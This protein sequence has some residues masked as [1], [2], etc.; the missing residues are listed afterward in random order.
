MIKTDKKKEAIVTGIVEVDDK[1]GGGIPLGSLC[2][3]EGHSDAGKSVLCQH[4]TNGTLLNAEISVAYYTTENNIR[5]LVS[6]M[7]SLNMNILDHFLADRLRIFPLTFRSGLPHGQKPFLVLTHHF[8][9]L[10]QEFKLI[11]VDSITLLVA[12]SEPVAIIDFFSR[13]KA[14]CDQGKTII[15]VAHSYAFEE[16]ILSRT[17]SLCDARFKLRLEQVGE[18]MIKL[19]EVLKVRGADRPTGD[20]VSFNIEPKL[21][22]R[23]IPLAKARV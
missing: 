15:V 5:S 3:V 22:M 4:L 16:D 13:C 14:L 20:V 8:S 7:D 23:I 12:H 18:T 11:I 9:N 10:P 2:L 1:L 6:Q 17:R 21:G 19:M